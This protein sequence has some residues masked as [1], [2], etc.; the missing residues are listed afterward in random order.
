MTPTE[1]STS[2]SNT[3][4]DKSSNVP[5]NLSNKDL[6]VK[7]SE[8]PSTSAPDSSNVLPTPSSPQP[9]SIISPTTFPLNSPTFKGILTQPIDALFS[10]Q[11]ID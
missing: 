10:S 9:N 2:K 1:G 3:E 6:N 8:N 4:E 5:E 7:M 11:S